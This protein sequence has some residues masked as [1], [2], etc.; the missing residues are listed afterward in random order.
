M[1]SGASFGKAAHWDLSEEVSFK[2]KPWSSQGASPEQS[3]GKDVSGIGNLKSTGHEAQ[4]CLGCS[5]TYMKSCAKW[6]R[7]VESDTQKNGKVEGGQIMKL[8]IGQSKKCWNYSVKVKVV[9]LCPTLYD[10]MDYIVHWI[11]QVRILEWVAFPFSRGSSQPRDQTQVSLIAGRLFISWA[12][13][14]AQEYW[15]G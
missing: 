13:R 3:Q 14:E 10:P 8:S 12:T 4:E 6:W 1:L 9:Q 15:N 5:R 2:Q 7:K 11:L